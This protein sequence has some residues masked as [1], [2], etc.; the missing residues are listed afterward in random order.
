LLAFR[1][2]EVMATASASDHRLELRN[3]IFVMAALYA[4]GGTTPVRVRNMSRGGALIEAAALP[5]VGTSVRLS[6]GSLSVAGE[7][8]WVGERKAGLR[9]ADPTVVADWLPSGKRGSG[10]Q[11]ID[12]VVH[13]ARL[14][15]V[16]KAAAAQSPADRTMGI[17]DELSRLAQLLDRAGE[18]LTS[19]NA[20]TSTHL[21]SLQM[22]DG[23]AQA[24]AKLAS[25]IHEMPSAASRADRVT[26]SRRSHT[27]CRAGE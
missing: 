26:A 21:V 11:L 16:A 6:R 7:V 9:F 20:I 15:G 27:A 4:S 12:E 25:A 10:Q 14:G 18:Q 8:T 2:A 23:V 1:L 3:N 17:A 22:I 13:L 5:V 24:L 19:D